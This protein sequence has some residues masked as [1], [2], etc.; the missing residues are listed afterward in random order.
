MDQLTVSPLREK[1]IDGPVPGVPPGGWGGLRGPVSTIPGLIGGN[2][3][4]NSLWTWL[5]SSPA[6]VPQVRL[7]GK[8]F[9]FLNGDQSQV[10]VFNPGGRDSPEK[11][12]SLGTRQIEGVIGLGLPYRLEY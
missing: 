1:V 4:N 3:P 8:S 2:A 10:A 12:E 9:Y 11:K 5:A 7:T 6:A